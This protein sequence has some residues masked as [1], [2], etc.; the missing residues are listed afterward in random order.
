M[1]T[2][3]NIDACECIDHGAKECL[4]KQDGYNPHVKDSV[5][6]CLD[7][8]YCGKPQHTPSSYEATPHTPTP[9]KISNINGLQIELPG[10]EIKGSVRVYS[11]YEDADFI[12]RAVNA[13]DEMYRILLAL[14]SEFEATPNKYEARIA[15]DI[16]KNAR[17]AIAKAEGSPIPNTEGK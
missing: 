1:K 17:E 7:E 8:H 3:K 6:T 9:W 13:H 2:R 10:E 11:S 5:C 12:V 15:M 4:G 14:T 16:I